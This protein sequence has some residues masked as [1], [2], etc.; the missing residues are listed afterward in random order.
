MLKEIF[1]AEMLRLMGAG[2]LETLYMTAVSSA[3]AYAIGLVIGV[4]LVIGREDGVRPMPRLCRLLGWIVNFVRSAPFLIFVVFV[5]PVTRFIT[6]TTLGATAMLVPLTLGGA[7]FIAR[8]VESSL[9]EVD[10]GVIEAAQSMG[11][12]AWQLVTRVLL[13]EAR[14]S[15]ISGAAISV[16]T[17]LSYSALAGFLGGGGLGAIATNYGYYRGN[18]QIMLVMIVA[19]VLL[20]QLVQTVGGYLARRADRRIK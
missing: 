17:I 12:G 18:S 9:R 10:A 5:M 15:L 11:A 8:M 20:V 14:P 3:A 16:T 1:S 4:V 19:L 7:P 6:G 2:L 13:P